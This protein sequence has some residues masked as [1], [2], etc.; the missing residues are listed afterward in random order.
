MAATGKD[1]ARVNLSIWGDDDWL[2]L[3]PSAQHLYLVLWTSPGLS[4]CGAGE[5]RPG[6]I[7]QRAAGWTVEAVEQAAA[8]LSRELF[9]LIDTTSE[10]FLL[11]SWVKHDQL[12]K[13]PH[14]AVSMAN[15]RADLASRNLRGVVVHEVQKIRRDNPNLGAWTKD[16]VVELLAQK[17]VDPA[18]LPEFT[19]SG[20]P[21]PD[22][23]SDPSRH[24]SRVDTVGV[25]VDPPSDPPST[26]SPSPLHSPAPSSGSPIQH[27]AA[28]LVRDIV[29]SDHPASVKTALRIKASELIH[30]GTDPEVV[31]DAL[32]RWVSKS[33]IGPGLLPALVSDVLKDRSGITARRDPKSGLLVER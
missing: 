6:K 29:P 14:M 11:R 3:S 31:K 12:W 17:A 1:H 2:D 13:Q 28:R 23:S 24:P 4:Y 16:S 18:S 7:S 26:P 27:D 8:E 21:P 33:G 32:T 5:W 9:L 10:E 19:P 15:A 20:H 22:P 25:T 30:A